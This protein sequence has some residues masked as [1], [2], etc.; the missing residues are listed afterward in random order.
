MSFLFLTIGCTRRIGRWL[1]KQPR[2]GA[3]ICQS[4][5]FICHSTTKGQLSFMVTV[6]CCDQNFIKQEIMENLFCFKVLQACASALPRFLHSS[7]I[8]SSGVSWQIKPRRL[9]RF[10]PSPVTRSAHSAH[11]LSV[12]PSVGNQTVRW[13][14]RRWS[15]QSP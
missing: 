1:P 8:A 14:C 6:L 3:R 7:I 2:L 9:L 4:T 13:S 12:A 15:R 5:F 10:A 11:P